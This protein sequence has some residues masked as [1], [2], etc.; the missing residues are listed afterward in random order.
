MRSFIIGMLGE[1]SRVIDNRHDKDL[2]CLAF[3]EVHQPTRLINTLDK[4]PQVLIV[5]S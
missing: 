1:R 3:V 5:A 4:G 2:T